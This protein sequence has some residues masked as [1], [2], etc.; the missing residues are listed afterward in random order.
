[1]EE[2]PN[3]YWEELERGGDVK[4]YASAYTAFVRAFSESTLDRELF[5][6][7]ARGADPA[8]VREEFFT[9]LEQATATDPAAGRYRAYVRTVVFA[10]R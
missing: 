10:R 2:V 1:M 6:P 9:D 8:A 5:E 4:E 3:P 7:G